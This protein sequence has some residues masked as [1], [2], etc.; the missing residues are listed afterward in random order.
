MTRQEDCTI[1]CRAQSA[2]RAKTRT[3]FHRDQLSRS[4]PFT[5]HATAGVLAALLQP[6]SQSGMPE[7]GMTRP[8]GRTITCRTRV[9]PR[10][11][12][13]TLLQKYRNES[14]EATHSSRHQHCCIP[15]VMPRRPEL[16]LA[17]EGYS[18]LGRDGRRA[19]SARGESHH[20]HLEHP[21]PEGKPTSLRIVCSES[22]CS[23]SKM[24]TAAGKTANA[25]LLPT[26]E[27]TITSLAVLIITHL[28]VMIP[29]PKKR[30]FRVF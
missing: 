20:S 14:A 1:K 29:P 10:A 21:H 15:R 12:T 26:G 2:P 5:P 4:C 18:R 25:V 8:G 13:R 16:I 7:S 6:S 11:N 22:C 24:R 3:P 27:S 23:L 28:C 19:R 9:A 17:Q 30:V